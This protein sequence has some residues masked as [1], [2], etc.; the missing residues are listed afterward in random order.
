MIITTSKSDVNIGYSYLNNY[1]DPFKSEK[2]KLTDESYVKNTLDYYANMAY[3]QYRANRDG[4]VRNY[5][6]M[7]GIISYRDFYNDD[8]TESNTQVKDFL[9]TLKEQELPA[10]IKHYSIINPPF[11]TLRGELSKRPDIHRVRAFDD[12]SRA[13]ELE[14]KTDIVQQVILAQAKDLILNKMAMRGENPD[15]LSEEQLQQMTYEKVQDLLTDYTSLAERWGNHTL[16]ALKA[17]FNIKEKSEEC[18]SDL[19]ICSRQ[20]YEIYED[21]SPTGFNVR[22][23]NPKNVWWKGTTDTKF[24]SGISG[25]SSVPYCMGTV[26]VKELSEIIQEFPELSTEEIDHLKQSTQNALLMDGRESNLF[27]DKTGIDTIHYNTY[28]R[29]ILQERMIMQSELGTEFRDDL[30]RFIGGSNAFSFGYKYVVVKAYWHSK[31]KIGRL[32][33]VDEQGNVQTSLVDETYKKSPNEVDIEW[34]WVN[35]WYQGSKI[36][37]HIYHI[38]P[39]EL[40]NYSPIIGLIHESKNTTPKSLV[41]QMKP[42]QSLFDVGM[43]QLWDLLEKEI[44]NVASV[45]LRRVPKPKG[46]DPNDAI[47]IWED[48]ARRR[49]IMFDDDSIENTKGATQNQTTARNIDLTR[50]NEMQARLNMCAQLQEMCW[51]L[52]GMNRQRLGSPLA[53]ETATANQNALVQSFAQTEP[54]FTAHNYVLTQLYQAMLDSA[55][56][57]ESSK[58]QS[59]LSYIT[60]QGESAFLQ[61]TGEDIKLR[62]LKVFVTS[63]AEDQQLFNDFRQLAQAM[64]QNGASLYEVSQLF[65]TNSLREMQKAFKDLKDKQDDFRNQQQQMDQQ[66]LDQEQQIAQAQMEQLERHHQDDLK[67]QKYI[68]DL[69]AN[70]DLAKAEIATYFQSPT[71]DSDNNGT[72]DIMEYANHQL[73]IQD[74]LQKR[75]LANKQLQLEQQKFMAEQENKKKDFDIAQEKLKN[76]KEKLSIQRKQAS[77]KPPSKK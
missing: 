75:D 72:P 69:K 37:P 34:G 24:T 3:S 6:L 77:K 41:D 40:L 57:I 52:V 47:D 39:F 74:Q 27:T 60:A 8:V 31:K 50:S 17:E 23:L 68:A 46:G 73:K 5:D 14:Y 12:D 18:F 42:L 25:D 58:P 76:D 70:T 56:Y 1:P 66:K 53:T 38:K 2:D 21:N 33:W 59:T 43:N 64:L 61:V 26:H 15:S 67:M 35:Q 4:F 51:Q 13:E 20:F 49:G 62:D 48:E 16:T 9:Q 10:H 44:G 7:K 32:R 54:Y 65:T 45:N 29:L 30:Q 71:T 55:Q 36:G 28:N 11:N 22:A 19:L 63:R